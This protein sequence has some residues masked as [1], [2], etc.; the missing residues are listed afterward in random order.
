ME[1]TGRQTD[2]WP[3]QRSYSLFV[4]KVIGLNIFGEAVLQLP[5]VTRLE[6][7]QTSHPAVSV[8]KIASL[9]D[10]GRNVIDCSFICLAY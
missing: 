1:E 7:G 8:D 5:F 3:L 10:R 6:W 2:I 4:H 9:L